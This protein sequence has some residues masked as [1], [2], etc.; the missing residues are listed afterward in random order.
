MIPS[1]QL[2][3]PFPFLL[4]PQLTQKS[5][6]GAVAVVPQDCILFNESILYNIRYGR[7]EASDEEV[8]EAARRAHIHDAIVSTF[9]QVRTCTFVLRSITYPTGM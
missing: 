1:K 9:P 4:P 3:T 8:M 7:P 5:V 6:R 2:N